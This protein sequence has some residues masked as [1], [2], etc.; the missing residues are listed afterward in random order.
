MY[1]IPAKHTLTFYSSALSSE[2]NRVRA[3]GG[4]KEG[5]L[6]SQNKQKPSLSSSFYYV[7]S[8]CPKREIVQY[9]SIFSLQIIT[10]WTSETIQ[11][12]SM[13]RWTK[14]WHLSLSKKYPIQKGGQ[15]N[16]TKSLQQSF[17]KFRNDSV[18]SAHRTYVSTTL[19]PLPT[20][21]VKVGM[22][23]KKKNHTM[24]IFH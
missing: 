3:Q 4:M 21:C 8:D 24:Y 17:H 7:F 11:H 13:R 16:A 9:L 2:I 18:L 14:W 23:L 6:D 12:G 22:L 10:C 20:S 5:N 19:R 15:D 1:G